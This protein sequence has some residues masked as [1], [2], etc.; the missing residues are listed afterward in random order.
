MALLTFVP[1]ESGSVPLGLFVVADGMGGHEGGEVASRLAVRSVTHY[2]LEHLLL[3]ALDEQFGE[4]L[5]PLMIAA[6][7]EANATIYAQGAAFNID[8]GTTCTAAL[9]LGN[10]I[11]VAHIGDSRLYVRTASTLVQATE[12]HSTVGRLIKLGQLSPAESREHPLRSQLYRTVGQQPQVVVDFIY[13]PLGEATHLLLCS[14][15]L[16]SMV[17][18]T[19]LDEVLGENL[20]PQDACHELIA[21][22]NLAGGEDNI[23]VVIVSLPSAEGAGQ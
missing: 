4:A 15:G 21:R 10:A 3:P 8:M 14:D 6:V 20:W 23:G 5:Q 17:E 19:I 18:D 22:A 1:R 9:L 12:D 13:Q 2:V 7:Q 11:Y 16:W